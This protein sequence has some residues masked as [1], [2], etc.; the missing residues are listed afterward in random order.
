VTRRQRI[1]DL[2]TFALPEQPALSPDGRTVVYVLTTADAAADR[3]TRS[4]WRASVP[5]GADVTGSQLTTGRRLTTGT[6]D[7]SPA[8]SPDGTR[9]AFLRG[10]DGPAQL[11]L[12]PADGGEPD[13]VTSLPL[14]AGAPAWSPDGTQIAFGAPVDLRAAADE[15]DAARAHRGAAPA[16][17]TRIDY[18]AD[19]AGLLGTIRK[20]LHVLD[21]VSGQV[22]QVTDGDWHASDPVWSPDS[23]KLAFCAATAADSDLVFRAP[24]YVVAV[25][26]GFAVPEIVAL[27]DGYGV[28]TAWSPDGTAL[29]V[30]GKAGDPVGHARLLRVPVAGDGDIIDLAGALDRNVMPGGPGYPGGRPA[31]ADGGATVLF[32]VRDRG[33]THVYAVPADGSGAPS[34]L[35]AG[36]GRVVS[37]LSVSGNTVAIVLAT[38]TSYGEIVTLDLASAT[39]TPVAE[40]VVTAHGANQADVELFVRVAREFAISDGTTVQAWLIRDPAAAGPGPLLVDIHGGPH[41]AWNGAADPAHLYHQELAARGWTVLLVNPRAS[42]GYGEAFYTATKGA[43]GTADAADFLEPV[44]AL[45]NEGIADPARLAV[46]GYSYGGFMTC[47]L[48][49]RD[50]RFAAAVG[51]GVV[52]DLTS[53]TG[54]SDEGQ[55]LAVGEWGVTSPADHDQD[56]T[57]G[58]DSFVASSPLSQ[59]GSVRTPTLLLHGE[60]DIRCPVGQAEQ[61][62]VA[63]RQLGVPVELVRYPGGS[64]L[65]ILDGPPSHRMDYNQRVTDWV[66]RYTGGSPKID[67]AHWERRLA[68]LAKRHKVP[69]ASLGIL[70]VTPGRA[71][72]LVTAAYGY[73]NEPARVTATTDTVFQIGSISKVWTATVAMQLADEGLLDLDAPVIEVLPELLLTDTEVAKTVTMR[74]LLTHTSGIDG[75]VFT[76]TGR[77]DDCVEKYVGLLGEVAQ[78]HPL[79]AT[80]SYCNSGFVLA[81]RVIEKLTGLS[82]DAALRQKL[83]APLGLTHTVTLP[84][85]ALLF[86]AAAGHVE[87]A[88]ER[89]IAPVWALPRSVGPAGLICSTPADVLAFARMHLSGGLAAD[90]TRL[91]SQ[92]STEAMASFQAEVPDKYVLGDSWGIGWIRFGWDDQ[93]LV[94]HDGNTIGQAA[95]LR[96]LPDPGNPGAGLAVTLLTNGGNTR[97]LYGDLY[98]EIFAALAGVAMPQPITPPVTPVAVDITPHL[99]TYERAS[100]R[101][102]V[103]AG[104]DGP[105]LRTT[106]LGPLAEMTPDPVS[107]Y[108]MTAVS[109]DLWLVREPDAQ[110]W[111]PVTF[112]ALGTGEKY[113][114]FGARATPK[115]G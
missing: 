70:R 110:T 42:D 24:V 55:T 98:Q 66:E 109:Q 53:M 105:M 71:D 37:G 19:G 100:V 61:W 90:G 13:Q 78:N 49:S 51:G 65:F 54:T 85:E 91:L 5:D 69:G 84:E 106:V 79:G 43:W 107:E 10:G 3:N 25:S 33:C 75:D 23:A 95:F 32:C 47:Y 62:H 94:G 16:V 26:G 56:R 64:H 46:T 44:D 27:A 87:V 30:V 35:V 81:G 58:Y 29:L 115:A 73:A 97:D 40:K 20:H 77:G 92:A 74:H 12:L 22:R 86:R 63:L 76:D 113:L 80:W 68:V 103:M 83:F 31:F 2:T 96:V 15:D 114:H 112:Y 101:M 34:P 50:S 38:P 17:T 60:S 36:A 1:E 52:S 6:A 102:E 41:N 67:V 11:W 88:G 108:P 45:V 9:V 89:Q 59:V 57:A 72:E 104:S 21:L 7:S 39:E 8:W 18:K 82:W 48:T 28:P 14:G 111:V 93:R 4:L 99:G